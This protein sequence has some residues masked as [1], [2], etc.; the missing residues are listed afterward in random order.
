[1]DKSIVKEADFF[2]SILLENK[3]AFEFQVKKL[4]PKSQISA[5]KAAAL[6]DL[7]EDGLM[8]VVAGGNFYGN[9]VHIGRQDAD[10]GSMLINKG[11][12]QFETKPLNNLSLQGQIRDIEKIKIGAK[13]MLLV[14][15]N[16]EAI[17]IIDFV[18]NENQE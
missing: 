7:N 5:L 12:G 10:F 6:I 9:T 3:G 11:N 1:L 4:P 17:K 18:T 15:R 14:A 8:D 16:N 2:E 13:E